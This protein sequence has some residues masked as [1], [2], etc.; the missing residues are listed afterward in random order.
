MG[1]GDQISPLLGIFVRHSG[2]RGYLMA[3]KS[4]FPLSGGGAIE[5]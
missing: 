2:P 3:G 5:S 1:Q 4:H